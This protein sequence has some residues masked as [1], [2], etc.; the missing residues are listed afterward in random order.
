MSKRWK[1][2]LLTRI[3][4][5]LA[6]VPMLSAPAQA[7]NTLQDHDRLYRTVQ[8]VGVPI[9]VNDPDLCKENWG[10]GSFTWNR[11]Q[12]KVAIT[13]CQDNGRRAGSGN[14]VRWTANDLDS[15]RHE[16]HHLVQ[17]CR[18][19]RGYGDG[20]VEPIFR[21]QDYWRFVRSVLSVDRINQIARNYDK[22]HHLIEFEAFAVADG[23]DASR[24]ANAVRNMCTF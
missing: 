16:S 19:G 4:S 11:S 15:L 22:D 14:Q 18:A 12:R 21:D 17:D 23:V 13:I 10:G 24:I 7:G 1:P 6:V 9:F 8:S 3:V 5:T 2:N 20:I